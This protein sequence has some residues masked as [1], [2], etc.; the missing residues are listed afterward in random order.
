MEETGRDPTE[1]LRMA[2]AKRA[3]LVDRRNEVR[4]QATQARRNAERQ[5]RLAAETM[6]SAEM[7]R[8]ETEARLA[9]R[10]SGT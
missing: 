2:L 8:H 10:R 5:Q 6:K 1:F 9:R 3:G 4:R 7:L